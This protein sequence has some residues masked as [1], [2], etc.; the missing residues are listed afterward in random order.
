[1]SFVSNKVVLFDYI[2]AGEKKYY[3]K[4]AVRDFI[5]CNVVV[6]AGKD[7]YANRRVRDDII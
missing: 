4:K 2:F 1:M 7:D 3:A 5:T 6:V